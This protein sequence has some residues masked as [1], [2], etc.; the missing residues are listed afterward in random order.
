M[1]A[2]KT[3]LKILFVVFAALICTLVILF[4]SSFVFMRIFNPS[5]GAVQARGRSPILYEVSHAPD[6][7]CASPFTRVFFCRGLR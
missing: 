4:I 5:V 1:K 6:K 2:S 7:S 3:L